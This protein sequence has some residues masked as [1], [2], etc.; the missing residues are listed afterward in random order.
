MRVGLFE[1]SDEIH[2]IHIRIQGENDQCLAGQGRNMVQEGRLSAARG[3]H[4]NAGQVLLNSNQ[5]GLNLTE[6]GNR[7]NAWEWCLL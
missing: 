5:D 6:P 7:I 1:T 3:T 4:E 2:S